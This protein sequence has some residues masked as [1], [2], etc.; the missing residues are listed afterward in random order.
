MRSLKALA[1]SLA[2]LALAIPFLFPQTVESQ[3][4]VEAPAGFDNGTNGCV[5]QAVHDQDRAVFETIEKK[6][7]GLGPTFNGTSCAGCHSTPISGG[8]S[9][10][11][12]LRAG[13]DDSSGNFVPATAFVDFGQEPI[14]NR[15]LINLQAICDAAKE[16]LTA[17]DDIR[18]LRLT[19]NTLGDGYVE[20]IAD[21]T[22][23]QIAAN[24]PAGMQGEVIVVPALE[25]GSGVGRFG[26]KDQHVSLLSFSSDAYLN[27]MGISNRLVPD[28]DDFTHQ[29]DTVPD[30][31]DTHDDIDTFARFMRATKVPPRDLT[32]SN[33]SDA[34]AGS[35]L[36]DQIG[37]STCHVRTIVTAPAAPS[38]NAFGGVP[39]C[40]ANKT[41]HPFSDF[42]LHKLGT[43]DK[44]VQN[45]PQDTAKKLRT[46]P[47][48]GLRTHPVFM[49][50][51]G[52]P[53]ISD[54]IERHA[55]EATGVI[56]SYNALSN[57]QQ[58]Q[59]LAFLNS[60]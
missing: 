21:A 22:L 24:Q 45:G 4:P 58:Q 30:P 41:I 26:W 28:Q 29:C 59:L 3:T 60:L 9:N 20:A 35:N 51:G 10:V 11:T 38:T 50:D 23:R 42:L 56:A 6:A 2:M 27:E 55:G 1:L 18:A 36:F 34:L 13:H 39:L 19:V 54:A 57:A 7:D 15:S 25:G 8:V 46:A 14:P 52:S 16:T 40:V 31:E 12:E 47:L 44:I 32:L 5:T 53:T 37:C 48:W 43:G 49:H 17:V 33:T